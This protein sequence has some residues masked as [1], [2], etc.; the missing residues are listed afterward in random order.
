M[1]KPGVREF[2]LTNSRPAEEPLLLMIAGGDDNDYL[3]AHSVSVKNGKIADKGVGE[4]M[5]CYWITPSAHETVVTITDKS[6]KPAVTYTVKVTNTKIAATKTATN[7][8]AK[9]AY[10]SAFKDGK[11]VAKDNKG[12]IFN[13]LEYGVGEGKVSYEAAGAYNDVTYTVTAGNEK[14]TK[15]LVTVTKDPSKSSGFDFTDCIEAVTGDD[16]TVALTNGAFTV[17]YAD[18]SGNFDIP[19][20]KY[21][22]TVTPLDDKGNA[23]AKTKVVAVTAAPAPKAKVTL[24]T[25]TLKDFVD[26]ASLSFSTMN[27]IVVSQSSNVDTPRIMFGAG[28]KPALLGI[29]TNGVINRF[30]SYF[31]VDGSKLICT[32]TP[33][34]GVG[35]YTDKSGISG[36]IAYRYQNLD[37]SIAFQY[38]KVKV[39]PKSG[40]KIVRYE[41]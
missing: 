9:N 11:E 4:G 22:F 2:V 23:V 12:K 15:A 36:W 3:V 19:K 17:R 37:G 1:A 6:V 34:D 40:D 29:N 32:T 24:K 13:H 27:N 5:D 7:V 38:V 35:G 14:I 26:S 16:G 25:V 33:V 41:P 30:A 10:D 20:G 8:V 18:A 21:E 31:K 28:E 39:T